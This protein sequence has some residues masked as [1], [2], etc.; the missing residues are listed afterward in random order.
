MDE[1]AFLPAT[2]QA[3]LVREGEVSPVELVETYLE[4]IE[5]I[6]PELGAFVTVCAEQALAAAREKATRR[7]GTLPRRA[8]RVQG[9]RHDGR[10]PHH[11]L[12]P[13]VRRERARLRPR[14]RR[15]DARG[16]LRRPRQDEHARVR[17]DRLHRLAAERAVPD[18]VGPRPERGRVE[19]RRGGRR[20][21]RARRDRTGLR[22]GRLDPDSGLVLRALRDQGL[23]WPGLEC[24]VRARHR[25]RHRRAARTD[26]ARRGGIPRPRHRL[27]VGRPVPG[28]APRAALRRGDRRRSGPPADRAH[29]RGADRHA[30]RSRLHRRSPRGGGAARLAR[31]RRRGGCPGLGRPG[32]DGG[33][34]PG[35]AGDSGALSDR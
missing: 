23:P 24:P 31:P 7:R 4:R 15:P 27:R 16:R 35:L 17:H 2:E 9:P 10:D 8:D 30:G 19:R 34:P 13:R 26:D 5:R 33:L 3:R 25:P 28:R 20:R 6:D 18:A 32:A 29:D 12:L 21:G 11:L 14:P 1:L 22:R